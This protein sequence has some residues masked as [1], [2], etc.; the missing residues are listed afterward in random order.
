[1]GSANGDTLYELI[2]FNEEIDEAL[3]YAVE[4]YVTVA[5]RTWEEA[6]HKDEFLAVLAHELRNPLAPVQTGIEVLR[7][8]QGMPA[9][10]RAPLNMMDR[11]MAHLVRLI[12]DLLVIARINRGKISLVLEPVAIG[13]VIRKAVEAT[14]FLLY[15]ENRNVSIE[16]PDEPAIVRG[17]P[18]RLAQIVENLLSNAS[19]YTY[20][21]GHISI[22][23]RR[24][25]QKVKIV[26][27]DDGVGIDAQNVDKVFEMFKQLDNMR[28]EGL[29]IGLALVRK[30]VELHDG[31][32]TGT[33]DGL[34]QGSKFEVS[35]PLLDSDV[36]SVVK[37][38]VPEKDSDESR[39]NAWK[40]L[41]VDDNV[42]AAESMN[43]LLQLL[44]AQTR[45]AHDGPTALIK[46]EEF[47]PNLV[48]LDIGLPGMDGY[49]VARRM[50]RQDQRSRIKIVAVS[51]WG[52][53]EDRQRS[54]HAGI[55]EHLVKPIKLGDLE[56]VL[57]VA[58]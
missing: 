13:D 5:E 15:A 52:Q 40:V 35:L 18:V 25:G 47:L 46:L 11:Q 22:A 44:G 6:R 48:L 23:V 19:K 24:E 8:T 53:E 54:L 10:T 32:V 26:V 43:M 7:L 36:Y 17:D 20:P 29:G 55:D 38:G 31:S 37:T 30:L 39:G 27:R 16:V 57:E 41:V 14:A 42:D 1:M 3:T 9:S 56:K 4:E 45:L 51:G 49:E 50:R 21:N 12:D 33:S 58:K 2:R 28:S 34:G